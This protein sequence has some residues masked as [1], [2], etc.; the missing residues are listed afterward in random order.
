MNGFEYSPEVDKNWP[1]SV[2]YFIYTFRLIGRKD[3]DSIQSWHGLGNQEPRKRV[4]VLKSTASHARKPLRRYDCD[5]AVRDGDGDAATGERWPR[6][7]D[8]RV[9]PPPITM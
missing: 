8:I 4:G 9:P 3:D 6:G 7:C 1:T 2:P 5:Y